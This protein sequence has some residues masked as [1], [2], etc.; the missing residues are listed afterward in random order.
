MA[1]P[2]Q[3]SLLVRLLSP[4]AQLREGEVAT[5]FLMF[6]YSFLAMTS[7]NIVKPITR[8]AYIESLG[9]D[10]LPW[11][12]FA[13]G[14]VIGLVMQAYSRVIA[15]VPRRWMVPV[16]QAGMIGLLLLFWFLFTRV[17][18]D[19]V[20][21][22]FYLL[23]LI[24]GILLISQFWTI[25]ND[26]YD[27]RRA[28]RT[29]GLIGGGAS[30]GGAMGAGI[31]SA[32]VQRL[33][34]NTMLLVSAAILTVCLGIVLLVLRRE[35]AAGTSNAAEGLEEEGVGGA[36]AIRMLRESRHL[37]IIAMVIGFAA[38]GAAIIEQQ[39]NM[40]A[41]ES[42]GS[43]D[44]IAAFLAQIIVYLSLIGFFI[45]VVLTSRIHR[46]LGIG[47]ALLI[48]PVSLGSTG[49]LMLLNGAVWTAA[50]ARIVD[51]SLRY[52]VDKT[53]REILF[54]PLPTDLKYRAKPFV[55]VT[56]DRISKGV[57]ALLI[58]VLIKDW[59]LGLS[60]QQLSYASLTMTALWIFFALRA[61][62]EYIAAF[63][64]SIEEQYVRP[65][66]IRLDTADLNTIET[67][68]S[69]LSHP[70]TRR[71]LYAIDLLESLDKRHLITPLLLHHEAPEVRARALM[72]AA[73][74][75]PDD[76]S[77]WARRA[78]AALKDPDATVRLAAVRALAAMRREEAAEMM[79]PALEDPD[80]RMA[81][82]A[83]SA[84]AMYGSEEDRARA[85]ET[86]RQLAT[87]T[88][89]QAI[90]IRLEVARALGELSDTRYRRLL[91]PLMFDSSLEVAREAVQSAGRLPADDFLFVPPLI[92]LMRNR[93]LKRY[94]R[95]VLTGYGEA[96]IDTLAYFLRDKDEDIW[97][98]R[99]VPS[100]LALIPSQKSL[101]VLMEALADEDGFI[102]YKAA[103]AID[104]I[105]RERPDLRVDRAII[106]RQILQEAR[107]SF[108]ALTLHHNLFVVGNLNPDS[109]LA[110]ALEEKHRRARGRIFRLLGM[111][112]PSEDIAAVRSALNSSDARL[113][114]GA[115]EYLDN[116][117]SGD[118]RKRVMLLIEEM[119]VEERI[120]RGNSLFKTRVRDV[121]D[122]LAQ[123]I[124]DD[125]EVIAAAAIQIVGQRSMWSLA[126]DLEHVLAHR[127]P[128]HWA[129]FEAAS[130]ALAAQRLSPERRRALWAEPLPAAELADRIRRIQ[131]FNFVSVN[132][133]FRIASLGRQVRFEAGRVLYEGG[134]PPESLLFLLDGKVTVE[135]S[136]PRTL[137]APA[138]LAFEHV[139]E[140]SAVPATVRA[141]EPSICLSLTTDEFLSL[142]SENVEI[143]QG[144]FRL[145]IE[146]GGSFVDT[147]G[148]AE[149]ERV[150][151]P[152][153]VHGELPHANEQRLARGI[154]AVDL[155]M[156]LQSSQALS[157]A[158][159][160]QLVALA[161]IAR[162]IELKVGA[163][164]LSGFEP[165]I[166]M[167]LS[168][169]IRV[170][171]EGQEPEVADAGDTIGVAETF[172]GLPTL[173]HG[174]VIR[175]GRAL[176]FSRTELF[177]VLAD[178]I[179]LVQSMFS[180]L[181]RTRIT[182]VPAC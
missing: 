127:D 88:R 1:E 19:W 132:E 66:E 61:R 21:V 48:L 20:A 109:L 153:V 59:G 126:G 76:A 56:M 143:T 154:Q 113:R 41:E 9:A 92:S 8:S 91:I 47:F 116:L 102:R 125:E 93:R 55:D 90:P 15:L 133:L 180:G 17:G 166:V 158:T 97:I 149:G 39:L 165:S 54:L 31:T 53:S 155:G 7:Y 163:D 10:N 99:H 72:A 45:Q 75:S 26:I 27:P 182:R 4:L 124:H 117:L 63:R 150:E 62:R 131:L 82:T 176:R 96:V 128:R 60:W 167:V 137:E 119:P 110:R 13:A 65:S 51:T 146:T 25:A 73:A 58:L 11:V 29:F 95:Q 22:G 107:R 40:A 28:K 142:L 157:R 141:S 71:V 2:A 179:D 103:A 79:R 37:Q 138:V 85:E 162:P 168:G 16:T 105:R 83:A 173:L 169:A 139:M 35:K 148:E 140:G 32:L 134:R 118:I 50:L 6:A 38:I 174:E 101:D 145:L 151:W 177:D 114:S 104:R 130:W 14:V 49:L 87:D 12:Q 24:L 175:E 33:G 120:R 121:E 171:R 100:T 144:I 178:N 152:A 30:L 81:V 44:A 69:E 36:E 78:E 129:V 3:R 57:G 156:L 46:Y 70:D 43:G 164:P 80:P 159:T 170:E 122:T 106:E 74:G 34:Q 5:A 68:V 64:R 77:H 89:E 172:G 86:L 108:S 111:L 161:S 136:R 23:G 160:A 115:V 84:L 52:T 18:A 112:Y 123:L 42:Q 147:L 135:G 181:L 98:R 67:L 94:A